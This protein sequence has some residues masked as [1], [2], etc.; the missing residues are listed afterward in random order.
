ME[1]VRHT[2]PCRAQPQVVRQQS[3]HYADRL[4][5]VSGRDGQGQKGP[6]QAY[7]EAHESTRENFK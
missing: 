2:G 1:L 4:A 6:L 5:E 7:H 3:C